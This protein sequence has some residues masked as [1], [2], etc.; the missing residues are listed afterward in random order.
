MENHHFPHHFLRKWPGHFPTRHFPPALPTTSGKCRFPSP[1]HTLSALAQQVEQGHWW[2]GQCVC[3]HVCVRTRGSGRRAGGWA[4]AAV[5]CGVERGCQASVSLHTGTLIHPPSS[6]PSLP[7]NAHPQGVPRCC[8]I[9]YTPP[10]THTRTHLR[11]PPACPGP[12]GGSSA[13]PW[14]H[15]GGQAGRVRC[16]GGR[17]Q[18]PLHV[19]ATNTEARGSSERCICDYT[20]VGA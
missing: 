7:C 3:A 2:L 11:R 6:P 19:S 16:S 8:R 14:R 18:G 12:P 5:V 1:A 9:Q 15:A 10:H 13:G 17:P 20:C 4:A